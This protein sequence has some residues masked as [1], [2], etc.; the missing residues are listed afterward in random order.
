M[1]QSQLTPEADAAA[2][3]KAMKGL[4][5]DEATIIKIVANRSNAQRQQ[6]KEMYSKLYSRDLIADLKSD[7]GGKFEDA[8]VALFD[9]PYM[10]DAKCLKKAMKGAGTDEDTV[11]EI[12]CTR[13]NWYLKNIMFAYKNLFDCDLIKDIKSDFSSN[14][15]NTLVT[16]LGLSRNENAQPDSATTQKYAE[17]L[18][19][20]G[21]KRAGTD[22]K[23][24]IN[25]LT[26]LSPQEM[27]LM[28]EQYKQIAGEDLIKSVD[29]EFSGSL[30]KAIRT[31]LYA[32]LDPSQYFADKVY[33]AVHGAGTKDRQ[34]MRVL[35]TRD[36]V[37]MPQIKECFKKKY[38]K[39]MVQYIKSDL[40]GD[41]K[42]LM[43]ELCDH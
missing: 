37:D 40:S 21:I 30:K 4:G 19:K 33:N 14:V 16:I 10:Y 34:L 17:D 18:F 6:I 2:L 35:I 8:V 29:K 7:L 42:K 1:E 15:K 31:I 23:V 12:I 32:N 20:G 38:N 26:K 5:T 11:I 28:A 25:I 27:Q 9:D 13:P 39:D 43:V 3:R 24:F 22:E 41:Y 36:E